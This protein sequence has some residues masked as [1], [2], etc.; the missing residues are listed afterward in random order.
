MRQRLSQERAVDGVRSSEKSH[1]E[2]REGNLRSHL[3]TEASASQP[4]VNVKPFLK[5]KLGFC[6]N[7]SI[8]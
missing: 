2:P 4:A 1:W 8:T 6:P 3:A 5:K 7:N